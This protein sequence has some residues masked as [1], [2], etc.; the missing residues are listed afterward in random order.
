MADNTA[1]GM[2]GFLCYHCRSAALSSF[3]PYSY[4]IIENNQKCAE[5]QKI[6][7]SL[8]LLGARSL[9]VT[10]FFLCDELSY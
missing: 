4:Y 1:K 3:T 9:G 8:R 7:L 5:F 10:G 2:L 6:H